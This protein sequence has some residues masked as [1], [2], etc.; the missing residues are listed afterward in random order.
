[1]AGIVVAPNSDNATFAD[2]AHNA[3]SLPAATQQITGAQDTLNLM[4]ALKSHKDSFQRLT[5]AVNIR[6]DAQLHVAT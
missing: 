5:I 6:D 2:H 1:M 4:Y 3:V